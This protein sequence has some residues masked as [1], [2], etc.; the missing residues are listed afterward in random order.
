MKDKH[1]NSLLK[2]VG[3]LLMFILG[4]NVSLSGIG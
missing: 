4:M 3:L 2:S 1:V